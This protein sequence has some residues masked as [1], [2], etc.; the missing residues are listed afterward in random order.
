MWTLVS[1]LQMRFVELLR[2][3]YR[4]LQTNRNSF[5]TSLQVLSR[6]RFRKLQKILNLKANDQSSC[7]LK[8]CRC[9]KWFENAAQNCG[10]TLQKF[11]TFHVNI[12]FPDEFFILTWILLDTYFRAKCVPPLQ[13]I[14]FARIRVWSKDG[15]VSLEG[16]RPCH[17][18]Q[19][20]SS[21]RSCFHKQRSSSKSQNCDCTGQRSSS[22]LVG[23]D[24][25]SNLNACDA[26]KPGSKMFITRRWFV[27]I[28]CYLTGNEMKS[29]GLGNYVF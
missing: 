4:N 20:K 15:P 2:R 10:A 7:V 13:F 1:L 11:L 21:F 28:G 8:Y 24:S 16:V 14:L 19:S 9:D 6:Q 18:F 25:K 22:V 29:H 17:I 23:V 3:I 12:W 26:E 5:G 27:A